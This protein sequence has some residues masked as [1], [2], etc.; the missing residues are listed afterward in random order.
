MELIHGLHKETLV[1]INGNLI[2]IGDI[3]IGDV[4]KGFDLD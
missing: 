3:K 1:E 4:L 2:K